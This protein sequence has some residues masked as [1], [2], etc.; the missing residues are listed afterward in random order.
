MH[1][2]N[3]LLNTLSQQIKNDWRSTYM[4]LHTT[5]LH[6]A[7]KYYRLL[8]CGK[9]TFVQTWNE[10]VSF[11]YTF[12]NFRLTIRCVSF[13]LLNTLMK[14]KLNVVLIKPMWVVLLFSTHAIEFYLFFFWKNS[15][16][17]LQYVTFHWLC[18]GDNVI[19]H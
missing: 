3:I 17:L 18:T 10:N 1:F 12:I 15:V 5:K 2:T 19:L 16:T 8:F 6:F 11:K 7:S 9:S 14:L 4:L 13:S